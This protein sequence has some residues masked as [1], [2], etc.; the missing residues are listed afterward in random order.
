MADRAAPVAQ[1]TD[2][3]PPA[4][5]P[6][7]VRAGAPLD[8]WLTRG[9]AAAAL[10]LMLGGFALALAQGGAAILADAPCAGIGALLAGGQR[11]DL[12]L[13]SAGVLLLCATPLVR[14]TTVLARELRLRCAA[15]ILAATLVLLELLLGVAGAL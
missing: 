13:M 2:A 5:P 6:L 8:R 12:V 3:A 15:G 10:A 7:A 14:M 11:P 1:R 9:L 4:T